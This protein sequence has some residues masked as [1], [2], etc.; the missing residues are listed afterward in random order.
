VTSDHPLREAPP[1]PALLHRFRVRVAISQIVD[2]EV[3]LPEPSALAAQEYVSKAL[4][5]GAQLEDLA[6]LFGEY[7]T[8]HPRY[9]K[10]ISAEQFPTR[11]E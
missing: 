11:E 4:D 1:D 2:V 7:L 6:A 5:A 10:V 3:F 8:W 9:L